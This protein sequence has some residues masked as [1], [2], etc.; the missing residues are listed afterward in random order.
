[1]E[2]KPSNLLLA[3]MKPALKKAF[4]ASFLAQIL[5][6]HLSLVLM[7]HQNYL[8]PDRQIDLGLRRPDASFGDALLRTSSGE[9]IKKRDYDNSQL[10]GSPRLEKY[11]DGKKTW[12]LTE[13]G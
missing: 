5:I 9:L 1:M 7:Q 8:K 2:I 6:L 3:S 12:Y 4:T 11:F 10:W 13:W